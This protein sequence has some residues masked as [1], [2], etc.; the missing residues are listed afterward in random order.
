MAPGGSHIPIGENVIMRSNGLILW[1]VGGSGIVL[2]YAAYKGS[3]IAGVLAGKPT[4]A[5]AYQTQKA[6]A[7]P[8]APLSPSNPFGTIIPPGSKPI[9]GI[10]A[11]P[12]FPTGVSNPTAYNPN[13]GQLA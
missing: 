2:V 8:S 4:S 7:N 9:P 10:P 5:P 11:V 12:G 1:L 13:T 3:T 6:T